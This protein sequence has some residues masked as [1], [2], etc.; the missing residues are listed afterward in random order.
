MNAFSIEL[1]E[2]RILANNTILNSDRLKGI[3]GTFDYIP[4][5]KSPKSKNNFSFISNNSEHMFVIEDKAKFKMG[6]SIKGDDF[7]TKSLSGDVSELLI[8]LEGDKKIKIK[9][10]SFSIANNKIYSLD[11]FFGYYNKS[12]SLFH[13]SAEVT[14]DSENR[15]IEVL[16]LNGIL[17]I[18]L[19]STASFPKVSRSHLTQRTTILGLYVFISPLFK[20]NL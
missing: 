1:E 19:G 12:D 7:N 11:S 2:G 18:F 14:F 20:L 9:S 15:K 4:P 6:V 16:N 10:N 3:K 17:K 13:P 8:L 5:K